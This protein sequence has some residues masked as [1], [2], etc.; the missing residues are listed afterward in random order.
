LATSPTSKS[1]LLSGAAKDDVLGADGNFTFSIADLL[2]NDPGGAAKVDI[3]KQFF[4]GDTAA[5]QANQSAYLTAHGIID[6]HDGTYT[7]GAGALD[8]NYFVQIGNKGTWSQ[9]AVDVTAPVPHAGAELFTEN[10]DNLSGTQIV[11]LASNTVVAMTTDLA[12]NGWTGTGG[13]SEVSA[14]GYQNIDSTT[15]GFWFDTQNSPGSIDVSHAFNDPTGGKA[16]LSFDI[17]VQSTDYNGQHYETDP[18]GSFSFKVDGNVVA[19]YSTQ[20]IINMGGQ[21]DLVHVD[22]L[23]DLAAGAHTLELVDNS[24]AG[25][26]GFAVDSIQVHDWVV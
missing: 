12:Q 20:D 13:H 26:A 21:N 3:T 11:D 19:T 4:F 5:D 22:L 1:A 23:V 2:A 9:A 10:F 15:G 8:F 14:S 6:N 18:N 16:Q 25:Y 24:V 17:G 7:I